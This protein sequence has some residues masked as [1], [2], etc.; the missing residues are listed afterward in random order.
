MTTPNLNLTTYNEIT[1]S[2]KFRTVSFE[3]GEDFWVQLSTNGGSTYVTRAAYVAGS[4]FQNNTFY[5][6]DLVIPGPFT[7]NTRIRLRADAS[8]DDDQLYI[9]DMVISGCQVAAREDLDEIASP[10]I[11]TV[12]AISGVNVYPNPVEDVLYIDYVLA[13][14][15]TVEVSVL[16]LQGRLIERQSQDL[17]EGMQH[18]GYDVQN[19]AAGT[20]LLMVSNN[21]QRSVKRFMVQR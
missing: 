10:L 6:V 4:G 8:A 9:D 5:S 1:V 13:E 12:D 11:T 18:Q 14:S 19:L 2:F 17:Q 3:N 16:D 7:S 15:G 20:Y 21:G